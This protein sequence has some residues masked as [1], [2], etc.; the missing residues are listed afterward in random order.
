[1][2][3]PKKVYEELAAEAH[4]IALFTLW[5]GGV[6]WLMVGYRLI[7]P[8]SFN[9]FAFWLEWNFD[10]TGWGIF[11]FLLAFL[12]GIGGLFYVPVFLWAVIFE[13]EDKVG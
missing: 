2:R 7:N 4:P 5:A 11:G 6:G 10:G 13:S 8:V 3:N 9:N 12:M 1:M